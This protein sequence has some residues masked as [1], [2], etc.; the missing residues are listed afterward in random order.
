MYIHIIAVW[1]YSIIFEFD[2]QKL[3]TL[4]AVGSLHCNKNFQLFCSKYYII[5]STKSITKLSAVF[6]LV[7]K[8][9]TDTNINVTEF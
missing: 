9:R 1:I 5:L 8:R 2:F 6:I 3:H 4:P 7:L